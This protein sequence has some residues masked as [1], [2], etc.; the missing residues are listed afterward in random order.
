MKF[1]FAA[2]LALTCTAF[3][4]ATALEMTATTR[5]VKEANLEITVTAQNAL[6][7]AAITKVNKDV[8]AILRCNK[9]NMFYKPGDSTADTDGCVGATISTI[10]KAETVNLPNV[11]FDS[12][13]G[14]S[15]NS[16]GF[17]GTSSRIIDLSGMVAQGATSIG[18]NA[19]R[20]SF[21]SCNNAVAMNVANVNTSIGTQTL[22]CHYDNSP[23]R[24]HDF[25]WSYN[26][27]TKQLS[28]SAVSSQVKQKATAENA[29]LTGITAAYTVTK[30]ML[31]VGDGK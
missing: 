13:P 18:V 8:L 14:G 16:K 2:T 17:I 23:N 3:S 30:T 27:S 7:S 11:L 29:K 24:R 20:T 15:T 4:A 22:T 12:Y 10:T 19:T 1:L 25:L 31:K 9:K 26:A 21:A 6:I 5:D 28:V